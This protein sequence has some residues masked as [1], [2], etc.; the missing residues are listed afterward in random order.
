MI[1]PGLG[2]PTM[3]ADEIRQQLF[4]TMWWNFAR[5]SFELGVLDEQ[6]LRNEFLQSAFA[7]KPV[8]EWWA[9]AQPYWQADLNSN[10]SRKGRRFIRIAAEEYRYA[11]ESGDPPPLQNIIDPPVSVKSTFAHI[12]PWLMPVSLAVGT[13]VGILLGSRRRGSSS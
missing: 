13:L 8:R 12:P 7:S 4:A 9:V 1:R 10:S 11:I 6:L 2:A 5:E 3:T